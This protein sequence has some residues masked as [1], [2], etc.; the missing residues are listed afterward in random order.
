MLGMAALPALGVPAP[1]TCGA[2]AAD[3]P[4]DASSDMLREC[5]RAADSATA[6]A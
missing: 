4:V 3:H 1:C 5:T 6:A 2:H